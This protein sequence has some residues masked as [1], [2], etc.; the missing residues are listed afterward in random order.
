M[1]VAAVLA[2]LPVIPWLAGR[3]QASL[4]AAALS[5]AVQFV[6]V[7]TMVLP[8]VADIFSAHDLAEHFNRLGQIPPRLFVAEERIGSFVFYLDPQLRAGLK[9]G[10]LQGLFAD[11]VPSFEVGDMVALPERKLSKIGEYLNLAEN[12]YESVGHYRLYRITSPAPPGD[13]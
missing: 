11:Q 6:A 4:A 2:P 3:W 13:G 9:Q 1:A 12:A 10:Q 7:M 8:P 5:L